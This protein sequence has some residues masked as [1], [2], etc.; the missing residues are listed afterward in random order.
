MKK[1]EVITEFCK[2][3]KDV[4]VKVFGGQ[5]AADCF[6]GEALNECD[7][8]SPEVMAYIQTAVREK[9]EKDLGNT[10][11]HPEEP[12]EGA[13]VAILVQAKEIVMTAHYT[14]AEMDDRNNVV[15]QEGMKWL[16]KM[17]NAN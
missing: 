1:R 13:H 14:D 9:I 7:A 15:E 2:L 10:L 16:R 11:L 4:M 5:F 6:C 12:V 3:S 8:F 17:P